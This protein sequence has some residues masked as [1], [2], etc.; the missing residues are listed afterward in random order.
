MATLQTR[1]MTLMTKPQSDA[2]RASLRDA[3]LHDHRRIERLFQSLLRAFQDDADEAATLWTQLDA[4]L[5]RHFQMEERELFPELAR[6]H[7]AA[8][9]ALVAEHAEMRR[10]LLVLGVGVDL[11]MTRFDMVQQ[12]VRKLQAHAVREDDV[13]YRWADEHLTEHKRVT[14]RARLLAGHASAFV[15]R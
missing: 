5:E 9:Q 3:M 1:N 11:H 13:L 12:L 2:P 15:A 8:T 4:A 6:T 7:P 14:L 10:E